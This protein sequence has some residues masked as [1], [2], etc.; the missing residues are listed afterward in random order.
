MARKCLKKIVERRFDFVTTHCYH[1]LPSTG[2]PLNLMFD[3]TFINNI[4]MKKKNAILQR[5]LKNQLTKMRKYKNKMMGILD[6]STSKKNLS[7][8]NIIYIKN[9]A[10]KF[11]SR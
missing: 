6:K 8:T 4:S 1:I 3:Y 7:N 11:Y 5:Y 2:H 9:S 10:L